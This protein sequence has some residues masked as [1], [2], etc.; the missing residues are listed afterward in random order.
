MPNKDP[1]CPSNSCDWKRD[2]QAAGCQQ[3]CSPLLQ[4]NMPAAQCLS[5]SNGSAHVLT[6]SS[7]AAGAGCRV[8]LF[9]KAAPRS[10]MTLH[11]AMLR[12]TCRSVDVI[13][14]APLWLSQPPPLTNIFFSVSSSVHVTDQPCWV[15]VHVTAF[16]L[17][18]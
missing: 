16:L 14:A 13:C 12:G 9:D 6:R 1:H 4:R 5:Y 8:G 7:V 11:V 10:C 3:V 18:A 17:P 2:Y 15:H